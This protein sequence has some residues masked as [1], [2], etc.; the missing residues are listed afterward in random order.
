MVGGQEEK[1]TKRHVIKW[2]AFAVCEAVVV[3]AEV[4]I[5]YSK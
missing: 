5:K 2:T 1:M 3:F 4:M